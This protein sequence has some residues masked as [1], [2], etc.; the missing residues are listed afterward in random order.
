ML[1]KKGQQAIKRMQWKAFFFNN[2]EKEY[3]RV[4]KFGFKSRKGPPQ[5]KDMIQFEN[6]LFEM[7]KKV[8]LHG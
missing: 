3:A 1:T 8:K 5:V 6:D 4:D 2:Q 7:I